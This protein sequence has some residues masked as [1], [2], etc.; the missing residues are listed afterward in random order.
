VL[1]RATCFPLDHRGILK[2]KRSGGRCK[3]GPEKASAIHALSH[4]LLQLTLKTWAMLIQDEWI[5]TYTKRH[6]SAVARERLR[7][8]TCDR[9]D[10]GWKLPRQDSNLRPVAW[11]SGASRPQTV[12]LRLKQDRTFRQSNGRPAKSRPRN[13]HRNRHRASGARELWRR[14]SVRDA[15]R[16]AAVSKDGGSMR[17]RRFCAHVGPC[18]TTR[19]LQVHHGPANATANR[20][21]IRRSAVRS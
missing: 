17:A 21:R 19:Y 18:T 12:Q 9:E 4:T 13:R 5:G 20:F 14:R 1:R 7:T 16:R 8:N 15:E 11:A 2:Q 6:V 3:D 10:A